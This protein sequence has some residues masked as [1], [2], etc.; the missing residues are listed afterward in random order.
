M[1][2]KGKTRIGKLKIYGQLCAAVGV[3]LL[4]FDNI[5]APDVLV[6]ESSPSRPSWLSW[7]I[8]AITAIGTTV[9]IVGNGYLQENLKFQYK[10]SS[11]IVQR[12]SR[13]NNH[14]LR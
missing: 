8:F 5:S 7:A 12:M 4:F 6:L 1:A 3:I 10:Q 9:Y 14:Y 13:K 11:N 2:G